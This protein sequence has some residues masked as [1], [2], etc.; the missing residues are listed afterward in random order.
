MAAITNLSWRT[1]IIKGEE[2]L[3]VMEKSKL[4]P[5]GRT[6]YFRNGQWITPVTPARKKK[7]KGLRD[8]GKIMNFSA[9][10]GSGAKGLSN[11]LVKEFPDK[12]FSE[13]MKMSY[14][15]IFSKKGKMKRKTGQ[16]EGGTDSGAFNMM[17]EI[18]VNSRIP[19][20]PCLGT[21][22]TTSLR[23]AYVGGDFIPG[24]MNWAIQASGSEILSVTL[25]AMHWLC[26]EY[27]IPVWFVI[28]IHDEIWWMTF[29][30]HSK[31][32]AALFQMAHL[33]TWG[34]FNHRLGINDLALSN[35][36][37]SGVAVDSRIRKS[38]D[39]ST[40]SPSNPNGDLEGLG[41][42]WTAQE[43][44]EEGIFEQLIPRST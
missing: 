22:I 28:S 8:I 31:K 13:L 23:P 32:A 40:V 33:Y 1:S 21:K 11:F 2:T 26:E 10:Y 12:Q 15:A 4:L 24:R 27:D 39:E 18:S 19:Q 36:F 37:F 35:A 3:D 30:E 14:R 5:D 20:L 16:F 44:A 6:A 34:L 25:V 41:K 42:E 9:L 29:K 38:V 7:L 17:R 43:L